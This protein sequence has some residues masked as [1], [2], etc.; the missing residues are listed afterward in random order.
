MVAA[1]KTH[2]QAAPSHPSGSLHCLCQAQLPLLTWMCSLGTL[3]S[4]LLERWSSRNL[5]PA[6]PFSP[7]RLSMAL[8]PSVMSKCS[9]SDFIALVVGL[10]KK[11]PFA[12]NFSGPGWELFEFQTEFQATVF[13]Q[14]PFVFSNGKCK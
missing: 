3:P 5:G 7:S 12:D 4:F 2:V 1:Q 8:R 14:L 11:L 10:L 9:F 13:S 6:S